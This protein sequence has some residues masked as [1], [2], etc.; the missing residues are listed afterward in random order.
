MHKRNKNIRSLGIAAIAGLCLL[1]TG[2]NALAVTGAT[3]VTVVVPAFLVLY[4]PTALTINLYDSSTATATASVTSS[5]SSPDT[6]GDATTLTVAS[7]DVFG[8]KSVNIPKAWAIRGMTTSGNARVQIALNNATL[9]ESTNNS[10]AKTITVSAQKINNA[11][12]DETIALTGMTPKYG[13]VALT[14]DM[15]GLNTGKSG[16]FTGTAPTYTITATAI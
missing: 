14:L 13:S 5:E 9:S 11:S 10:P 3:T 15:S 1:G 12:N 8:S 7:S 4:Y 6:F 2:N 16:T